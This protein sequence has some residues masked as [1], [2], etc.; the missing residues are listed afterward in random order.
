MLLI[1]MSNAS[2][3]ARRSKKIS[4]HEKYLKTCKQFLNHL[5]KDDTLRLVSPCS[6][7]VGDI[8][9]FLSV[10]AQETKSLFSTNRNNMCLCVCSVVLR[11]VHTNT[12]LMGLMGTHPN[13]SVVFNIHRS[14]E[15]IN[16]NSYAYE[17][18]EDENVTQ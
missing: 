4:L 9:F 1:G 11:N 18:V 15:L 2:G 17:T 5:H 7:P 3:N 10:L 6:H 13:K 12:L 8:I 16:R 14:S